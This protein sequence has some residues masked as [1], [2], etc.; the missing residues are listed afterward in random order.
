MRPGDVAFEPQHEHMDWT[1]PRIVRDVVAS[2]LFA[3]PSGLG[4]GRLNHLDPASSDNAS[5]RA[6]LLR[7]G[8]AILV[9]THNIAG[10]PTLAATVTLLNRRVTDEGPVN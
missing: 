3:G 10:L 8:T 9:G 1:F 2:G 7:R 4:W 6:S 5:Q